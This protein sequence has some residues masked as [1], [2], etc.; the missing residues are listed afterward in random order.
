MIAC[1]E[2]ESFF[3]CRPA[4]FGLIFQAAQSWPALSW[5]ALARRSKNLLNQVFFSPCFKFFEFLL[6]DMHLPFDKISPQNAL[7]ARHRTP[8][9]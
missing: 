6:F 1:E 5:L 7:Q 3:Q 8:V 2:E 4:P 9:D